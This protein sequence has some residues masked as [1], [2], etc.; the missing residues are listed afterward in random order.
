MARN[1]VQFHH[2]TSLTEFETRRY[3]SEA[4]RY[5]A[6]YKARCPRASDGH[7]SGVAAVRGETANG[8][9]H[10]QYRHCRH[11][12]TLGSRT[13]LA[14]NRLPLRA[15]PLT[16]CLLTTTKAYVA[17]LELMRHLSVNCKTAW[18]LKHKVLRAMA[19]RSTTRHLHGFVRIDD[20]PLG[21][22]RNGGKRGRGAPGKQAFVAAVETDVTMEHL[23]Y[24]VLEPVRLRQCLT[25]GLVPAPPG[26]GG[27][28][29]QRWTGLLCAG[30]RYRARALGAGD[31]LRPGGV[32]S[33]RCQMGQRRAR[34]HQMRHQRSLLH[35]QALEICAA[36]PG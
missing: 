33:A 11:Q 18:R 26:A 27:R 3:S 34:Q 31:G 9:V 13:L 30:R 25:A 1:R 21:G 20:A 2:G 17:A 4:E 23:R 7:Q 19:S 8:Q 22:E 29:L 6:L 24:A 10:Y 14:H 16:V 36:T 28:C 32:R 15:W 35:D 5:R 12:T